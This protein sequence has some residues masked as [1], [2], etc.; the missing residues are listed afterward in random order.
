MTLVEF[1]RML[2]LKPAGSEVK[3]AFCIRDLIFD[4]YLAELS[5]ESLANR[6]THAYTDLLAALMRVT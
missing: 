4:Y 6:C 2:S 3:G 1:E 5:D